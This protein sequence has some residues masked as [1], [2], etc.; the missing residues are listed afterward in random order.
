MKLQ[1]MGPGASQFQLDQG[2]MLHPANALARKAHYADL[3]PT[4][5]NSC[6]SYPHHYNPHHTFHNSTTETRRLALSIL[7]VESPVDVSLQQ[8]SIWATSS[9]SSTIYAGGTL[10]GTAYYTVAYS[11][12]R[13]RNTHDDNAHDSN[14]CTSY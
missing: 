14:A 11:G 10:S 4:D 13:D 3:P 9:L 5:T 12:T 2:W 8:E 7:P 1:A 6:H